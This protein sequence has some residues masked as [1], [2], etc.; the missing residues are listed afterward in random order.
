MIT[1]FTFSPSMLLILLCCL[2]LAATGCSKGPSF[3]NATKLDLRLLGLEIHNAGSST[4]ADLEAKSADAKKI[5]QSGHYVVLPGID[6]SLSNDERS[7]I[8]IAYHKDTPTKGGYA[9]FADGSVEQFTVEG[10]QKAQKW[11]SK[12]TSPNTASESTMSR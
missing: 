6:M 3:E 12:S 11:S 10:F 8:I 9:L 1:L 7:K 4:A 5:I 2:L